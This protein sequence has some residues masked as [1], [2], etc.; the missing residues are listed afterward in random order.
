MQI[1]RKGAV[2]SAPTTPL[3]ADMSHDQRHRAHNVSL[4]VLLF[5]L[6]AC[7]AQ[8]SDGWKR[9]DDGSAPRLADLEDCHAEARREAEA[10]HPPRR[11]NQGGV[12][13]TFENQDLFRAELSF[14]E[15][16]MR[17]KGFDRP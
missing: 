8:Q 13:M 15:I 10:R 1:A 2:G 3:A 17:R 6:T 11:V 12:E 7:Q 14:F 5:A 16:C 4:L 9:R